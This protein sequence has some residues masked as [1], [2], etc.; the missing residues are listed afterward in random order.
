[1]TKQPAW[2]L[3]PY[4]LPQEIKNE[5]KNKKIGY[6]FLFP[7]NP[8]SSVLKLKIAK[9]SEKTEAIISV[10]YVEKR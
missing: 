9:L 4:L 1:M 8:C 7:I 10:R 5:D 2:L 6:G 3:F